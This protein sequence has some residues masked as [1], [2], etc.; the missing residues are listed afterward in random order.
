MHPHRTLVLLALLP[1]VST[2]LRLTVPRLAPSP[3]VAR[4]QPP[5]LCSADSKVDAPHEVG[6]SCGT[7]LLDS[8]EQTTS[9]LLE[10][11]A[12]TTSGDRI[13]F[14]L[15]LLE[16]GSSS[17]Q[18]LAALEE[19]GSRRGVQ[20]SFGLDVSYVSMLSRLT[21]KTTTLIPR[22][23]S[24][25]ISQPEWCTCTYGSKPD[26]SK[27]AANCTALLKPSS[28]RPLLRRR[29][30]HTVRG[31]YA[32]FMRPD[33]RSSAILGG[34]NIGDRFR[35]GRL[36]AQRLSL[37]SH[38]LAT[39]IAITSCPPPLPDANPDMRAPA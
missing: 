23:E 29:C 8:Y 25:A 38:S 31:R 39:A 17:E 27:C 30:A 6:T 4:L 33:G 10:E 34:M 35:C 32:L 14:Q 16:G 5:V 12:D 19:A 20:V 11:I 37:S 26:H 15:Y 1:S 13:F 22:V 24:M 2:L 3:L 28:P 21:E 9:T 18:V 7:F 36:R